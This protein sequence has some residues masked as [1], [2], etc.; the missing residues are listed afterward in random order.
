MEGQAVEA[1]G[2]KFKR[3]VKKPE[4]SNPQEADIDAYGRD[5]K[6]KRIEKIQSTK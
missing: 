6:T 2:N 3:N 5:I 4:K 1:K